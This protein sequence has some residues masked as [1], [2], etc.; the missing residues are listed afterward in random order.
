MD[1]VLAKPEMLNEVSIL[2]YD[3]DVYSFTKISVD[4]NNNQFTGS[5]YTNCQQK[6]GLKPLKVLY[7]NPFG[8]SR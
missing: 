7:F 8:R 6:E 5:F 2:N 1:Q 3:T 4:L